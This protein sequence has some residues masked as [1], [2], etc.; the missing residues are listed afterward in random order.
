MTYCLLERC[1]DAFRL[2]IICRCLKISPGGYYDGSAR[3]WGARAQANEALLKHIRQ[4]HDDTDRVAG[5]PH[6][7]GDL[8][9]AGIACGN[10][11]IARR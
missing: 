4:L 8:Q 1:R 10:A 11:R 7:W 3:P 9:Y 6:I 5:A 2:R